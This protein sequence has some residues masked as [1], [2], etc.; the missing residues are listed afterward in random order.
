MQKDGGLSAVTALGQWGTS[1]K[2]KDRSGLA[3]EN[4]FLGIHFNC[5]TCLVPL[6]CKILLLYTIMETK[7]KKI[8]M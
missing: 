5:G 3:T 6:E 2:Q 7:L 4:V 8:K 1:A